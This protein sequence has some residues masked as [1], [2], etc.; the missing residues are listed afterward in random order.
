MSKITIAQRLRYKF[1]NFMSKGTIA[2]IGGLALV[3]LAFILL[4]GFLVSLTGIAPEGS[5][6]LNPLEAIWGVLMRTLDA[7]TMGGDTGWIFRIAMLIVTFGGIFLISTLIGVLSTGIDTKLEN[8]RKGRS[9]VIETNHIVI[10]GWSLQVFTLISELAIAN[11]NRPNTCIV[12]LSE[13]DKVE[14]EDALQQNLGKLPRIRLV[15]RTGSPSNMADLGIASIQTA[16]SIIILNPP[17]EHADIQLVKTLLAI[18]NIHR[19][20]AHPYHIVAQV[21]NSKSLDIL[22]LVGRN[23]V[24][25]LL[26]HDLISRIVVQT[27]RQSGLSIVYM[28]LL[29]FSGN[30]IYFKEEPTLQGQSYGNALLAYNDSA[31]MGIKRSDNAILLNPPI[32]TTLQAGEQLIFISEDDDKIHL[33]GHS[34]LPIDR[35][36][37]RLAERRPVKAENTLILGWSDRVPDIMQLLDQ[38]VAPGSTLTVVAEFPEA[39]VDLSPESLVLQ[40]QTVQ[41]HQGN[42]TDRQVLE[43]LKLTE[44]HHVIVLSNTNLEPEQADAQTLVTLLHLRDIADRSNHKFQVVT[45]ILDVRNQTLAQVARPDDFVIGEQIVSRMLA[46]VAEHKHLNAV[47]ADLFDPEGAEIYLKPVVDYV[48][49]DRPV[50]FYT[51]VEAAK[52]R[53]ES[54]IGYRCKADANN[55]ARSY[56]VVI[57]P[58]KDRLITFAPQDTIIVLAEN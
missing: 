30:E 28:D 58:T 45:E 26:T 17:N 29:D 15:C 47:F 22:K 52:Q 6:R 11:A 13:E 57:N 24:E 2:L 1:D 43:N 38:Y 49:I 31:V 44:Y 16:R 21:Q 7:G 18:T 48:V 41:Y 56:G 33:S 37:I 23:E 53:G 3:S 46:Q 27:C 36:L 5:D 32:D 54:A 25:F 9:R 20:V 14:M 10:L 8:L 35:Q 40:Q 12:I 4:M 39:E 50:N 42:P 55:M 19:A 34:D 51:I